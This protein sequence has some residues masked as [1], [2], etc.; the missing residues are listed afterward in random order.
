MIG[1]CRDLPRQ[2]REMDGHRRNILSSAFHHI[3]I[4]VY[5][6]NSGIVWMTQDFSN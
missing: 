2:Q 5:R 6:D 4:A 1:C 3:G